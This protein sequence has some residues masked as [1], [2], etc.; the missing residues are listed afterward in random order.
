MEFILEG[1]RFYNLE[2]QYMSDPH[3]PQ[4]KYRTFDCDG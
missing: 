4:E 3:V 2:I 1:F